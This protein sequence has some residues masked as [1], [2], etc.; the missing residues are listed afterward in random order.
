M[1]RI[2]TKGPFF[3]DTSSGFLETPQI[4]S[5]LPIVDYFLRKGFQPES[6]C[7]T[8]HLFTLR[9]D[10]DIPVSCNSWR[11]SNHIIYSQMTLQI[12]AIAWVLTKLSK[13]LCRLSRAKVVRGSD[14]LKYPKFI[15][16]LSAREVIS[17]N[18][19][20]ILGLSEDRSVPYKPYLLY[21]GRPKHRSTLN[22][23]NYLLWYSVPRCQ[24]T[25]Y[26]IL[27]LL[28]GDFT[29]SAYSVMLQELAPVK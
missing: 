20:R 21:L 25:Y 26:A 9:G 10:S 16:C 17:D 1:Q 13:P 24:P 15:Q 5:R 22:R 8:L 11:V 4:R 19:P 14:V 29:T 2:Y 3:G 7:H 23:N 27:R 6:R 28:Y 12:A 18:D